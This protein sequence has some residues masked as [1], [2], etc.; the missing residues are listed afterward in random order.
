V[1][2]RVCQCVFVCVCFRACVCFV[3]VCVCVFVCMCLCV[4]VCVGVFVC[5]R[6][7]VCVYVYGCVW[8]F[9]CVR[10]C[11]CVCECVFVCVLVCLFVSVFVR[12]CV[13]VSFCVRGFVCVCVCLVVCVFVCMCVYVRSFGRD[14]RAGSLT[15]PAGANFAI[16]SGCR[17]GSDFATFCEGFFEYGAAGEICV[18]HVCSK[19]AVRF[20]IGF[21]RLIYYL[22][23]LSS[24]NSAQKNGKEQENG[25]KNFF[26]FGTHAGSWAFTRVPTF[27]TPPVYPRIKKPL[28]YV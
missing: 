11:K 16:T 22:G 18:E 25:R 14:F 3:C 12:L 24:H 26:A 23:V 15:P 27:V 8:V 5:L 13:Y 4:F 7:C 17:G 20:K 2:V 19:C 10:V 21:T 6:V 1:C 9:V 28:V